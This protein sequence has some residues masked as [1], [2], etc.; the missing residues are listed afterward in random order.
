MRNGTYPLM[1]TSE[2]RRPVY[3][4]CSNISFTENYVNIHIDKVWT[5]IDRLTTKY[6]SDLCDKVEWNFFSAVT[7]SVL[8]HSCTTWT[9]MKRLEKKLDQIYTK[10]H[11][12]LNKLWKQ[13]STKLQKESLKRLPNEASIFSAETTAIDLAMN[14]SKS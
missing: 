3:N 13:H 14:I 7:A 11:P 4:P 1:F 12:I 6:T 10:L 2:I 9:L 5:A 8:L